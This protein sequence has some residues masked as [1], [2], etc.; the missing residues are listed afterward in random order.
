M[1]AITEYG[2]V[3][4]W[5]HSFSTLALNGKSEVLLYYYSVIVIVLSLYYYVTDIILQYYNLPF[6]IVVHP[7]FL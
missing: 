4:L 3:D 5:T 7:L 2:C 1:H 6:Y